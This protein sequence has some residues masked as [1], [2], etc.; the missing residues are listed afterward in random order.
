MHKFQK[1]LDTLK[2]PQ[3]T[4]LVEAINQAFNACFESIVKYSAIDPFTGDKKQYHR[5]TEEI[6]LLMFEKEEALQQIMEAWKNREPSDEQLEFL[7][8]KRPIAEVDGN[9]LVALTEHPMWNQFRKFAGNVYADRINKIKELKGKE[10][11]ITVRNRLRNKKLDSKHAIDPR[12]FKQEQ[13][14]Q[15]NR[16]KRLD[17]GL[18]DFAKKE[19]A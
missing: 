8:S 13:L 9:N 11:E 14:I 18:K 5:L 17:Q 10:A 12:L 4:T 19:M 6:P 16:M 1:F 15:K 3:N 7:M 2:T